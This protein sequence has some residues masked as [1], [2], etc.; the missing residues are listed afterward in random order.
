MDIPDSDTFTKSSEQL[1]TF[2]YNA[3][4]SAENDVRS[5]D[6]KAQIVGI[7]Y[8]FTLGIITNIGKLHPAETYFLPANIFLS[9]MIGILPIILFGSVLYPSR[10]TA[11]SYE[12]EGVKINKL[13]FIE[14][15]KNMRI[16]NYGNLLD[17]S[18]FK[19][20]LVFELIK[21][22]G[23]RELKRKRFIRALWASAI[24]YLLIFVSQFYRST[25]SLLF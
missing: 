13:Y 4:N 24:S 14:S 23:L 20:E 22:S 2:L 17:Q 8:I 18:D 1:M 16:N 19:Q 15:T 12:D 7:G 25:G 11:P 3:V 10:K 5:Y 6:T 21:L 9:W